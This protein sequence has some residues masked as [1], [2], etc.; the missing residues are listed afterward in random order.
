MAQPT[1]MQHLWGVSA[2]R[3]QLPEWLCRAVLVPGCI[4]V[5]IKGCLRQRCHALPGASYTVG[6]TCF[7][8]TGHELGAFGLCC[9][10]QQM[11]DRGWKEPHD[12]QPETVL[13]CTVLVGFISIKDGSEVCAMHIQQGSYIFL[14][15]GTRALMSWLWHN[16]DPTI[17]SM[18]VYMTHIQEDPLAACGTSAGSDQVCWICIALFCWNNSGRHGQVLVLMQAKHDC[19]AYIMGPISFDPSVID[20]TLQT[21]YPSRHVVAALL[22]LLTHTH[23]GIA[24]RVWQCPHSMHGSIAHATNRRRLRLTVNGSARQ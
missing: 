18:F 13:V 6:C 7:F 19:G 9:L 21:Y 16:C 15:A 10:P 11:P 1:V 12:R 23:C 3:V 24:R 22:V 2:R 20:L 8:D 4:G 5:G 17:S 14:A